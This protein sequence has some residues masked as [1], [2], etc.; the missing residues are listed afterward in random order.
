[1]T[2]NAFQNPLKYKLTYLSYNSGHTLSRARVQKGVSPERNVA[3][4]FGELSKI[5]TFM[6]SNAS[7]FA[8]K[9][10]ATIVFSSWT[11]GGTISGRPGST[12]RERSRGGLFDSVAR[13]FPSYNCFAFGFFLVCRLVI[14]QRRAWDVVDSYN[15]LRGNA[16]K[17]WIDSMW[18]WVRWRSCRRI[19]F[20]KNAE[21]ALYEIC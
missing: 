14:F 17:K 10:N 5:R 1:M 6:I 20:G 16:H 11:S 8:L 13:A 9:A 3:T 21:S 7:L 18:H 19:F 12:E 4:L 2:Q 15:I